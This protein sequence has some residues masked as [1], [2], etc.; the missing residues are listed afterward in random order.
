MEAQILLMMKMV[1]KL[2]ISVEGTIETELS[3]ALDV[4]R[5]DTVIAASLHGT[6]ISHWKDPED[7]SCMSWYL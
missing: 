4:I 1:G 2:A 6:Q 5:E 3:G 7:L